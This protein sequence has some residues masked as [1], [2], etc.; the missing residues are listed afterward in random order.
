MKKAT[1]LG[2]RIAGTSL[3][4]AIARSAQSR[5]AEAASGR[6]YARK[7]REENRAYFDRLYGGS[8]TP[9]PHCGAPMR[10]T[11]DLSCD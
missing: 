3:G 5:R 4:A 1:T 9:C 10:P 6:D 11:G 7:W 2:S 8:S